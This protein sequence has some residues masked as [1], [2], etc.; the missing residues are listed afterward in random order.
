MYNVYKRLKLDKMIKICWYI[1]KKFKY[2]IIIF[3]YRDILF[4]NFSL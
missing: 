1:L 3:F 4:I 2:L